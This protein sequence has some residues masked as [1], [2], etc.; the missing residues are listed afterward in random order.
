MGS[1]SRVIIRKLIQLAGMVLA[2]L[3]MPTAAQGYL[4]PGFVG[5]SPQ[6]PA[7]AKDF[8]LMREAGVRSVRLPLN[9]ISIEPESPAVAERRWEGFDHEVR[10]AAAEGLRIMPF[11][12]SSPEWVAAQGTDLPVATGH[13]RRAWAAFLRAAVGRYGD[14]GS[15]WRE[16]LALPYLPMRRWEIWNE[17]NIVSFAT[18]PEPKRFATL[19]RIAGRVIHREQPLSTVIVGGLFG[20][21]LQIP[22]NVASGDFLARFYRAGNVKPF[23]DGVAL[24]PYVAEAKA[25]G[26]QLKNLRR[27]M[28]RNG[29]GGVPLYV[30]ELG[31]GSEDGPTRWQQG[32]FGQAQQ[33]S[34]S[35]AM[36]SRNRIKWKVAG[37]WWFTW[38]DEGGSCVFCH[39]AGLL[40]GERRAK[41]S[42]YRFV[43]WTGGNP[44]AVR[45]A[46]GLE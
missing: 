24:H 32:V 42:W 34:K 4:P 46:E 23:F 9:W 40:T 37:V 25:M 29:D 44:D 21:P 17:E 22:P 38:T 15:F 36:L 8:R 6:N 1:H 5:L 28:R 45:P 2:L 30:T 10:L 35:F 39:S 11:V 27:I 19:I 3:T 12:S 31:W 16:N 14:G 33:L 43:E 13:Q 20:R 7:S 41:P 26:G 18:D